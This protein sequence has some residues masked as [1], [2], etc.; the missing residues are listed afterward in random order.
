MAGASTEE[1]EEE[2]SANVPLQAR[3]LRLSVQ[4]APGSPQTMHQLPWLRWLQSVIFGSDAAV[5]LPE[6]ISPSS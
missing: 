3:R 5:R 6:I 1:A 4:Q 2:V